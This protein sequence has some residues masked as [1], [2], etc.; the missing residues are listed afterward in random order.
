MV[1]RKVVPGSARSAIVFSHGAPLPLGQIRAPFLPA[2]AGRQAAMESLLLGALPAHVDS[3][4]TGFRFSGPVASAPVIEY[5]AR[6]V[7]ATLQACA[8][9]PRGECGASP[10]KI[11]L[12][13][14]RHAASRCGAR[15]ASSACA[16]ATSALTR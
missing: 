15:P 14:P 11:S 8:T 16:C 6:S 9:Q 2:F 1:V 3:P 7:S 13:V 12:I 5:Q 10:S 4:T